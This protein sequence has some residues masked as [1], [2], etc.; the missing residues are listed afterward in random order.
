[1]IDVVVGGARRGVGEVSS[2][3][4]VR[5]AAS[6]SA[7]ARARGTAASSRGPA[8]RRRRRLTAVSRPRGLLYAAQTSS[9]VRFAAADSLSICRIR[10]IH[11]KAPTN[12]TRENCPRLTIEVAQIAFRTATLTIT[13]TLTFTS[14]LDLQSSESCGHDPQ[15]C[16]RSRSK[17]ISFRS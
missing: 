11:N 4:R 2:S 17:I 9:L 6:G 5:S 16:K 8:W 10:Q 12:R 15:T 14:D 7:R 13:I 3:G 1:M